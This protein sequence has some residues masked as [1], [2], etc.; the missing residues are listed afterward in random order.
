MRHL[1][2]LCL[3]PDT[4]CML[5]LTGACVTEWLE[6]SASVFH[7]IVAGSA[8][9]ML[10]DPAHPASSFD[11]FEGLTYSI[12]LTQ[13][14]RYGP[15]GALRDPTARRVTGISCFGRP[16]LG[17]DRVLVATNGYRA[18]GG[19]GFPGMASGEMVHD[20]G[21]PIRDI[22]LRY[23]SDRDEFR[24]G[25]LGGWGFRPVA[26]ASVLYDTSPRALPHLDALS[27]VTVRSVSGGPDGFVRLHLR[28]GPA[29]PQSAHKD[30]ATA[31]QPPAE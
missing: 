27:G 12:D 9:Q 10:L 3:H 13:P 24:P 19:A 17:G 23:L 18:A 8:E 26:G 14:A 30:R 22:L 16:L 7:R 4:L 29:S 2:D 11:V 21:E 28:L 25:P 5:R 20:R 31:D 15:D 1:A 6:R